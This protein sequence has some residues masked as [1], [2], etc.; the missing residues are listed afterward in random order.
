MDD[1]LLDKIAEPFNVNLP[2]YKTLES[3]LNEVLP[4]VQSFGETRFEEDGPLTQINWVRMT[5]MVGDTTLRLYRFQ[6]GSSEIQIANDG[7]MD[8][9]SYSI[10]PDNRRRII[11]GQ[12]LYRDSVL[13]ELAFLDNDFLILKR[14]G[15]LANVDERR[16]YLLFCS[17]PLGTRLTWDEALEKLVAKY[18]NSAMPWQWIIVILLLGLAAVVYLT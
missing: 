10:L 2:E 5:D 15:N 16:R 18:R 7:D 12:S 8:S 3:M 17:E 14:H 13:Y 1:R 6:P 4:V 9:L 11:I